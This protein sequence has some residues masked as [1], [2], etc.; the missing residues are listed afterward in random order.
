MPWEF[1]AEKNFIKYN[2]EYQRKI[3]D[4]FTDPSNPIIHEIKDTWV[5]ILLLVPF[6]LTPSKN[7]ARTS[8]YK[9]N[10]RGLRKAIQENIL[11]DFF[12]EQKKKYLTPLNIWKP[13]INI[14]EF[15]SGSFVIQ[16]DFI[17]R[18]PY[19][20][21]DDTDFYIID[22]PIKK[23]WVFKV[24]YIASGQWKGTLRSAMAQI[25]KEKAKDFSQERFQMSLLFGNEK[26]NLARFFREAKPEADSLYNDKIK[27]HYK[28]EKNAPFSSH[29]G[30]L[31][32]YPTYFTEIGLEVINP[33]PRD[34]GAGSNPIYFETVPAG[35]KGTFTLLYVPLDCIGEDEKEIE[36]QAFIDLKMIAEGIKAMMTQYG[37]GA[38]TSSGFG[39][40]EDEVSDGKLALNART[41]EEKISIEF[42]SFTDFV[43][44]T[45]TLTSKVR[46]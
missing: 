22:N 20:S 46:T 19:L 38:K 16:F 6:S 45:S 18:K 3:I 2:E 43:E 42:K 24:P 41:E 12:E 35:A 11:D 8:D 29:R 13:D 28:I 7:Y 14:E 44:K 26:D 4:S 5:K 39:L 10:P 40:A 32:F 25:L 36:K 17:L 9:N 23:E 15:S 37:F 1:L 27:E 31:Y 21:K 34:T 33:H 30:R